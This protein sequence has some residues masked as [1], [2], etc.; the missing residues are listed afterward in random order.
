LEL[1]I[2]AVALLVAAGQLQLQR[3][4]IQ[5]SNR[6]NSLIHTSTLLK[7][8][9]EFYERIIQN[10][11]NRKIDWTKHA[12]HVNRELQPLLHKVNSELF[13]SVFHSESRIDIDNVKKALRLPEMSDY[14]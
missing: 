3:R 4:D 12:N 14:E 11:K 1:L 5:R 9:I 7:D 13:D 10:L 8:R 2:A 6:I